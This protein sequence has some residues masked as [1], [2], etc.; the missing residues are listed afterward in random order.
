MDSKEG[1]F[2]FMDFKEVWMEMFVFVF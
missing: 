2:F 1:V